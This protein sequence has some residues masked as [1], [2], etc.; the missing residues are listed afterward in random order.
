MAN[1]SLA[2]GN[3]LCKYDEYLEPNLK[4]TSYDMPF[5]TQTKKRSMHKHRL[6]SILPPPTINKNQEFLS[7]TLPEKCSKKVIDEPQNRNPTI[8]SRKNYQQKK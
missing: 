7:E 6:S 4:R 8:L 3:V 2:N 5:V 1:N